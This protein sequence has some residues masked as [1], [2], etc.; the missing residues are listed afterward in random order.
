M[1]CW[2]VPTY[3]GIHDGESLGHKGVVKSKG[4]CGIGGVRRIGSVPMM[5]ID[6]AIARMMSELMTLRK[7]IIGLFV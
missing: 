7:L 6:S 2:F 5:G 1:L 4:D 3:S